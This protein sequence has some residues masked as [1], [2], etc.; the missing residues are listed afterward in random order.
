MYNIIHSLI[1][2]MTAILNNSFRCRDRVVYT[3]K[4]SVI[5]AEILRSEH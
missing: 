2:D 1:N 4:V 5:T 3:I